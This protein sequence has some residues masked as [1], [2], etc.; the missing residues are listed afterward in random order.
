MSI[1]INKSVVSESIAVG[2]V[3]QTI[4]QQMGERLTRAINALAEEI[5]FG[6]DPTTEE[7][8]LLIQFARRM[9]EIRNSLTELPRLEYLP[10]LEAMFNAGQ[11][12]TK[13]VDYRPG[14][15]TITLAGVLS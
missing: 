7:G 8:K 6:C 15:P 12:D 10:L 5:N 1:E 9:E 4:M 14:N 2:I 3:T 11:L 13:K